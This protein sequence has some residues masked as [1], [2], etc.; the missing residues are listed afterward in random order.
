[1]AQY[2]GGF[3]GDRAGL[4]NL[5]SQLGNIAQ[6]NQRQQ[7][8]DTQAQFMR[9]QED[10]RNQA[11]ANQLRQQALMTPGQ[12]ALQRAQTAWYNAMA[13][14]AGAGTG[15][16]KATP[17]AIKDAAGN[18]VGFQDPGNAI[19]DVRGGGA[20][21]LGD[22][23]AGGLGYFFTPGGPVQKGLGGA[24]A[25]TGMNLLMNKA[26]DFSHPSE[27]N[28]R[29]MEGLAGTGSPYDPL[30]KPTAT[31]TPMAGAMSKKLSGVKSTAPQNVTKRANRNVGLP[32]VATPP[33][34]SELSSPY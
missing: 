25:A 33:I 32:T 30:L 2:G 21:V 34:P 28:Q 6:M 18:T 4:M 15:P 14:N 19:T 1:M 20:Q 22:T 27:V 24:A 17:E 8:M 29:I 16:T 13:K 9:S 23:L 12:L 3:A 5:E 26:Y 11:F 31:P 7:Q 10:F